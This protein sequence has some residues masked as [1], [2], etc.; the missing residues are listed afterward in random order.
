VGPVTRLARRAAL[1]ALERWQTGRLTVHLPDGTVQSGGHADAEPRATLWIERDVFFRRLALKGDLGAGESYMAGDWRTDD[2]A[3]FLEIGLLNQQALPLASWFSRVLNLPNDLR[4][5]VRPNT[6]PGS[7]RN[8]GAHYD[9][10][11]EL[12]ALFLDPSMTYSSAVFDRADQPL[13]EAQTRK[14]EWLADRLG[15]A[16]GHHVLDIGCGWGAFALF[17][18]RWR[19]CRVTGITISRE[20]HRLA[21]ARIREAGLSGRVDIRLCDYRDL[22]GQFDRIVSIEMIE[23][24][25]R[26]HWPRFFATCDRVL[27]PGGRIAI[28]TIAMPDHRFGEYLR[29]A[30]WIQT[31][32]F[33]GG[34]LP[35]LSEL[36]R[37]M[38]RQTR[39]GIVHLEDI[40]L[41]Y[42]STL[43]RWRAA[44]LENLDRVRALGFDDRFLRM[45]EFYLASCEA[46]FRTRMLWTYQIVLARG[47]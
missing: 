27:A 1:A 3:R 22:E 18:A 38:M 13:E 26:A 37:A 31:Y 7:R 36:S 42:A 5:L 34:L 21:A 32:I 20:Q 8:I 35:S 16:A 14:F 41:H 47:L 44:F 39:L 11:N 12:F 43:A 19:G 24:V 29:H 28:Q 9:L 17:A 6:K 23:A 15:L 40:G 2:L 30:D 45:W 10:S 33:P 25:G 4:H 46:M